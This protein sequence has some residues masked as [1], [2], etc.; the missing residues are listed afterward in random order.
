MKKEIASRD[1]GEMVMDKLKEAD[2]VSYVRFASVYK[3]FKN[4]DTFMDELA[5]M[6]K[7]KEQRKG[8]K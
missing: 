8:E 1:I 4:I 6:L 7:E 2:E 3:Q 5:I